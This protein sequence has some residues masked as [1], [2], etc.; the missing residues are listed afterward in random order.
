MIIHL[1]FLSTTQNHSK[2]QTCLHFVKSHLKYRPVP[3]LLWSFY[4]H[5][6]GGKWPFCIGCLRKKKSGWGQITRSSVCLLRFKNQRVHAN[7]P[8][9][10]QPP[11]PP[12]L[13]NYSWLREKSTWFQPK[14]HKTKTMESLILNGTGCIHEKAER[15]KRK[16]KKKK[17]EW[18]VLLRGLFKQKEKS[19]HWYLKK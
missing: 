6:S 9:P 18:T 14:A 10:Q 12:L 16:K 7:F 15:K 4:N 13:L 5:K 3:V 2:L 8:I 17:K 1:S 11:P 19:S